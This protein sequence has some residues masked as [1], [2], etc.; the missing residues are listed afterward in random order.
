VGRLDRIKQF[1]RETDEQVCDE[2]WPTPSG[3]AIVTPSLPLVWQLNAVRVDDPEAD[4]ATAVAE[5]EELLADFAHRKLVTHHEDVGARLAPTL[6][7]R[8]WNATRLLVMVRRRPPDRPPAPGVG[9]EVSR[10]RGAAM[11]AAFRRE[12]P[13][14]WQDEA[15]HQLAAMDERYSSAVSARDFAAPPDEPGCSCRLYTAGGIAQ[16]DEVGTVEARRGRGYARAAV[17]AAADAAAAGGCDPVFLLTDAADWPRR[18]YERLGFDAIGSVYEF[19]K[20]PL[21]TLRS[22]GRR[23]S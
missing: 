19:L 6:T 23:R 11:L 4:A 13:F 22:G 18:L 5:A 1:L 14:G 3:L 10:E 7:A 17:L 12:Q 21:E 9:A 16:I 2:R 20:L 15:I 8:G